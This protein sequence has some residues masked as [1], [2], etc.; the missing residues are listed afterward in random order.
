MQGSEGSIYQLDRRKKKFGFRRVQLIQE[1]LEEEDHHGKGTTFLFELNNVRIFI[2]GIQVNSP[3]SST[4]TPLVLGSNW[5]PAD[6]YLTLVKPDRLRGLL[7]LVKDGNQNMVRVWGGGIYESDAFYEICDG[8]HLAS[9]FVDCNSVVVVSELGLL[10]WQDFPFACGVYPVFDDFLSTI[11]LEAVENVLRLRH[12][13]SLVLF[14]GN[15]E[16][17]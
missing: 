3:S 1:P 9:G 10:V 5:I 16:G 4:L 8:K 7:Q 14:C 12:H 2:G 11:K 15:N 13:P 17:K 6:V